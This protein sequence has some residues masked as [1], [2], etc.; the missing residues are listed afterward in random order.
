[1]VSAGKAIS[2]VHV[3]Q[4]PGDS[5]V[6]WGGLSTRAWPPSVLTLSSFFPGDL[7]HSHLVARIPKVLFL[8][9][10]CSFWLV[11]PND[12]YPNILSFLVIGKSNISNM[13]S[14]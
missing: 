14:I 12:C 11:F 10:N 7:A 9:Y 3:P 13:S 1:M 6:G 5:G 8:T 2:M 4:A